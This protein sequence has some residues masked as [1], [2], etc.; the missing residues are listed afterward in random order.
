MH[1]RCLGMNMQWSNTYIIIIIMVTFICM[2]A[3]SY[4]HFVS[5]EHAHYWLWLC[6]QD[7]YVFIHDAI[8]ESVTC[9]DTQISA[10]DLRRQIQKMSAV[11]PGKT[12]S[13]FQYQFQILEQVS[14]NPDE[15]NCT[16]ALKHKDLNRGTQYL[17]SE[18]LKTDEMMNITQ[19]SSVL[20]DNSPLQ[21]RIMTKSCAGLRNSNPGRALWPTLCS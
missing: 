16:A 6:V 12:T 15:V 8:L 3:Y 19:W 1:N 17:P 14:P 20:K 18:Y 11:A 21:R 4:C 5:T 7:Q 10:G 2:Y 9:G 13:G